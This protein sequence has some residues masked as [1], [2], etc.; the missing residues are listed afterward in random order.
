VLANQNL[1]Q[2]GTC[3]NNFCDVFNLAQGPPAYT[4]LTYSTNGPGAGTI[5]LPGTGPNAIES[6]TRPGIFTMP[7]IYAYNL[8]VEQQL[9]KKMAAS[10]AYVGN[11][12]RHGPLGTNNNFD[13]NAVYFLPGYTGNLNLLRPFDGLLGPRYDYGWTQPVDNYCNCAN[14]QYNS[15][16]GMLKIQAAAG[17]T[18][19]GNYTYQVSKGDGFGPD[20][21]Y[22]FLYDRPLGYGNSNL[23][24]HN[25]VVFAGN[26]DLP[27]GRGRKY[28]SNVNRFVDAALGGWSLGGIFTYYSGI[29]FMPSIGSYPANTGQPF[30][31]PNNVPNVGMGSPYP[32][33]QNRNQWIVTESPA[34]LTA[35]TGP[36]ALPAPNTFG[37]YPINTLIG[38]QFV[39]VDASVMK[40][41][42][43]TEHLKFL[44]RMDA[45]N[46]FNHANLDLP[47]GGS[48]NPDITSAV[49]GQI[50]NIAFNGNGYTMRRVQFSGTFS[51]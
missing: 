23:M 17:L 25:Q 15:F 27:F 38:P 44:V 50:T 7:V 42:S 31:G 40:Q 9:T 51:W 48:S 45:T 22:T 39:N 35:G 3:G 30:A 10:A 24:P 26:Y 21:N 1:T 13:N 12:G 29:P 41:F 34:T 46:A 33:N 47:N 28:G 32:A 8:T 11:S 14:S 6:K 2:T 20:D 18:L 43:L 16:Q 5:V 37:N 49:G 36:F 4:G 19:Q